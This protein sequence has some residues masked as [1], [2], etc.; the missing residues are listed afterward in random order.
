MRLFFILRFRKAILSMSNAFLVKAFCFFK[1]MVSVAFVGVV[2][3]GGLDFGMERL[4][5]S[6]T[7]WLTRGKIFRC[8]SCCEMEPCVSLVLGCRRVGGV[9]VENAILI[10]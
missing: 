7:I 4:C 10:E 5:R 6:S 9:T 1:T 2:D 8:C 3:V